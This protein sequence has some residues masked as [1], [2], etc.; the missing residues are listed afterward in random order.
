MR[1][2]APATRTRD[3]A[4][5]TAANA[6]DCSSKP[7][8]FAGMAKVLVNAGADTNLIN[9]RGYVDVGGRVQCRHADMWTH[10]YGRGHRCA[11]MRAVVL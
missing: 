5:I 2:T 7:E 9:T 6:A 1:G 3:T 4:L 10:V 11:L 8:V